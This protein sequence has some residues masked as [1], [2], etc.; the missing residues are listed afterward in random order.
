VVAITDRPIVDLARR[1]TEAQR[2][3]EPLSTLAS[4]LEERAYVYRSWR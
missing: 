1:V 3:P 2:S 4:G